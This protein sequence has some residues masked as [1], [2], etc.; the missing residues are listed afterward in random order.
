MSRAPKLSHSTRLTSTQ[1]ASTGQLRRASV[2]LT[3]SQSSR[4]HVAPACPGVQGRSGVGE[5][6]RHRRVQEGGGNS[7]PSA[8][9]LHIQ[10]ISTSFQP[11]V[12]PTRSNILF[13]GN[14]SFFQSRPKCIER[15]SECTRGPVVKG[16]SSALGLGRAS[17]GDGLPIPRTSLGNAPGPRR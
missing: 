5:R 9:I 3:S 4:A 16:G 8:P 2:G 7:R 15:V 17:L 10:Q 12:K 1:C 14:F 11:G 13:D 6:S